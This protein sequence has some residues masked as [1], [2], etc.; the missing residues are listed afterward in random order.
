MIRT[1]LMALLAA[2]SVGPS[3]SAGGPGFSGAVKDAAGNLLVGVEIL[4]IAPAISSNPV[5]PVATVRSDAEGRFLVERLEAGA[6]QIVAVKRGY[7]TYI[8]RVNTRVDQWIQLVLYPQARLDAARLSVPDDDAWALRLP[9]RNILRETAAV[10]PEFELAAAPR[11]AL[12]DLPVNL[13][14]DQLFKV[15]T[16]LQ[17]APQDDSVVQGFET[18]LNVTV[19]LGVRGRVS[20]DGSRERLTDSRFADDSAPTRLESD[21]LSAQFSYDTSISTRIGVEAAYAGRSARWSPREGVA[22]ALDHDQASWRGAVGFEKQFGA[23]THLLVALDYASSTLSLPVDLA[24]QVEALDPLSSNRAFTGSGTLT[25]T[26]ERGRRFELDFNLRHLDLSSPNLYATSNQ[27]LLNFSGLPGWTGG[28]RARETRDLAQRFSLIYGIGYRHVVRDTDSSLWTP[29]LGGWLKLEPLQVRWIAT[30]YGVDGRSANRSPTGGWSPRRHVGYEAAIEWPLAK[31]TTLRGSLE[32]RPLMTHRLDN[33]IGDPVPVAGPVYVTD[34]NATL[35]RNRVALT[36]RTPTLLLFAEV[37]RGVIDGS[38]A[39]VLAYDLPFQEIADRNLSYLNGRLG[40][41]FIP[42]GT[43]VTLELRGVQESRKA[44]PASDSAQRHVE[45]T[46]VQDVLQRDDLGRWRF[47]VSLSVA[48][49]TAGD[50]DDL[51]QI[52]SADRLDATDS[53]LSAGL[54]LE[55]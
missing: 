55:F 31:N 43:L 27:A 14:V 9:R 39:A 20:A 44:M 26:G 8:G 49:W 10:L 48:E 33:G 45:L 25:R 46:L 16:D 54:S 28:I 40:L 53:R 17:R 11:P 5:R 51:R 3:V 41:R 6:Y 19:P 30:Y 38:V 18:R 22:P 35:A 23:A 42:Q 29:H 15:A 32:S 52:A 50:P 1:L 13:K 2:L 47:L 7:R 34:G 21:R 37:S 24:N 4:V 12:L 36:R